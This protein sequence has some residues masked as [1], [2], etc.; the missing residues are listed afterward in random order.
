[1]IAA[2]DAGQE[3]AKPPVFIAPTADHDF[4]AGPAFGFAPIGTLRPER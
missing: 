3:R 2:M 1:M 4:M